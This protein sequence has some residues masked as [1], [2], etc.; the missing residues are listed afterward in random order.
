MPFSSKIPTRPSNQYKPS[1]RAQKT[2]NMSSF[3]ETETRDEFGIEKLIS[4]LEKKTREKILSININTMAEKEGLSR[5][6]IIDAF[7]SQERPKGSVEV[8][9]KHKECLRVFQVWYQNYLPKNERTGLHEKINRSQVNAKIKSNP[10]E[11][12][13]TTMGFKNRMRSFISQG[14]ET[15]VIRNTAI[16]FLAKAYPK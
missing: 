1:V 15:Q 8:K 7:K 6:D 9:K 16:K 14:S 12:S 11:Y 4:T 13:E 2:K 3:V 5:L 10:V